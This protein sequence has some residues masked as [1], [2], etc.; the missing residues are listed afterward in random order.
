MKVQ[1]NKFSTAVLSLVPFFLYS[2]CRTLT[3]ENWCL[4]CISIL[5]RWG[6][7]KKGKKVLLCGKIIS[8]QYVINDALRSLN[9]ISM[10]GGAHDPF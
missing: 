1:E 9:G 7:E 10:R 2:T 3:F 4:T 5:L 8:S 6:L